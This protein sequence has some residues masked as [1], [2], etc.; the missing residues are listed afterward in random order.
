MFKF[1]CR[2]WACLLL[3]AT[4]SQAQ[5]WNINVLTDSISVVGPYSDTRP[6]VFSQRQTRYTDPVRKFGLHFRNGMENE[7]N[8]RV[9]IANLMGSPILGAHG[10]GTVLRY[11][12]HFSSDGGQSFP[13]LCVTNG[14]KIAFGPQA[15]I[16]LVLPNSF[17]T[18]QFWCLGDGTGTIEFMP[19]FIADRSNLGLADSGLGSI[20][21]SNC[22]LVT[23]ETQGLPLG[24]RPNPSQINAHLVFEHQPGST[25]I[26]KT[27]PQ[28]YK[29]GLWVS[30]SMTLETE[31][32]LTISGVRSVWTDYTNY[33][34]VFLEDSGVVLRKTGP[35]AFILSGNQG[36]APYT[37]MELLSGKI[38]FQ[39]DPYVA[40]DSS[41]Y[42]SANRKT[43]QN[44]K[45]EIEQNAVAHFSA[46]TNH[47]NTL[48][49]K[50]AA[51]S[52]WLS[53]GSILK[54][55]WAQLKG[56]FRLISHPGDNFQA[57]DSLHIFQFGNQ[58][59]QFDELELPQLSQ[60]LAW[61]TSSLYTAG[62]LKVRQNTSIGLQSKVGK[63]TQIIWPNPA[64]DF[65][66]LNWNGHA[67]V[68]TKLELHSAD[69]KRLCLQKAS[70][71][72]RYPIAHLAS[73]VYFVHLY[74]PNE[75]QKII[76]L[77]KI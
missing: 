29:G 48:A 23:H 33:G 2:G 25:W 61:D 26:T 43:G 13:S 69:G 28:E 38:W 67:E 76:R 64:S 7:M 10:E 32:D 60:N 37:R 73:G 49:C 47:L 68:E 63:E 19:G 72:N 46:P 31:T 22:K 21:L 24:Y 52:L 9:T 11:N 58:E 42:A 30:K 18:R 20:R 56:K 59:G 8:N 4:Q 71:S 55:K 27:N 35:A 5:N 14:G 44:L 41:L 45:L 16:D 75:P 17:F 34:G 1:I 77:I 15:K 74:S 62:I 3:L 65:F 70:F 36:Y 57:G 6:I 50:S 39:T 51:S 12:G 54:A 40:A 53:N 66:E